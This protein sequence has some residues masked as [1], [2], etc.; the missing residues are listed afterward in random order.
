MWGALL[1][2]PVW[3]PDIPAFAPQSELYF[4]LTL[5][6][7]RCYRQATAMGVMGSIE[8]LISEFEAAGEAEVKRLIVANAYDGPHL[9]HAIH[10]LGERASAHAH[11]PDPVPDPEAKWRA[12][13]RQIDALIRGALVATG[14]V[15]VV[16]LV[17]VALQYVPHGF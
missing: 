8:E 15:A 3:T 4:H 14:V 12:T 11:G 7:E 6:S 10:W 5:F 2:E 9:A 16:G 13:D 17:V 1:R